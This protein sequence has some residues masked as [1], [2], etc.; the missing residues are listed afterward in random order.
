MKKVIALSL[1]LNILCHSYAQQTVAIGSTTTKS[2]AILW[3]NGNGSQ[4]LII[5]IGNK[6]NVPSPEKGMVIYNDGD[7]KVYFHNGSTW[8]PI[9]G[10]SGSA[11][12]LSYDGT[13]RQLTLSGGGG[14][15][16]VTAQDLTKTGNTLALS[17]DVTPVNIANTAPTLAG[18]ILQ[19]DAASGNWTSSTAAAPTNGQVL[20]WNDTTKRWQPSADDAGAAVAVDNTSI[21]FNGST[22]LEVKAAGITDA[23]VATGIAGTKISPNFGTQNISTTGNLSAAIGTFSGSL[24]I[25]A[26]PYVW[27]AANAAGVL[28]NNGTGTLS[29]S[30][31]AVGTVTS[32]GLTMPAI[33]SVTGSPITTSGTFAT[34][35]AS[36]A[37]GTVLAAP[38][39]ANGVPSFRA[40]AASDIPTLGINKL[41]GAG[42]STKAILGS[43]NNTVSWV[44]G[45][46]N[47]VLGTDGTGTLA[48]LDKSTLSFTTDNVIP[49]GSASGLVASSIYDNGFVGIGTV[50]PTRVVE[51]NSNGNIYGISHVDGDIRLST[52]NGMLSGGGIGG[53]IGTESNHPFYIYVANSGEKATFLPNGNVGIGTNTPTVRLQVDAGATQEV[54]RFVSSNNPYA[55]WA[56]G[57]TQVGFIQAFNSDF[58]F[59]AYGT[60]NAVLYT[61]GG[62]ALIANSSANVGVARAPTVNRF[63][64]NGNASKTTAGDWLA[65]SDRR[66]KT[67]IQ[68]VSDGIETVKKLR[69]VTFRYTD[70]WMKQH[71]EIQSKIYY[72]FIAQ[73]YQR[74]FPE[75]VQGSGEFI[76]GDTKEVLQIDTYNAQIVGIKAIQELI[77]KVEILEKENQLL[78]RDKDIT[79]AKLDDEHVALER[80]KAEVLE[81]KRILNLEAKK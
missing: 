3:L 2:N 44:T 52:Y 59:G 7:S 29:W 32:V 40:L 68:T 60:G 24:S 6:D 48:F 25:R 10:G 1:L 49:K 54:A 64:V 23:K 4:A 69:P 79:Q 45:G 71:P 72:N 20:K 11:Q 50:S 47:Q 65:N 73:E 58:Y 80:L 37:T 55:V 21:G 33:F 61:S 22:Q 57:G 34:T 41:N 56:E 36:Q 31:A 13:T 16:T 9:G 5:P 35:L 27:P 38:V 77:E 81:I 28:S 70:A 17:N 67:D 30:P 63:E 76:V 8:S 46:V 51:V 19:W 62:Q 18:Q 12:T 26:V 39:A 15:V 75:S 43:D 66:I 78:K 53:A 42:A 74:V 14:T